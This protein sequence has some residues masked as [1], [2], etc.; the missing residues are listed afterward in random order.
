MAKDD[1]DVIV[2]NILVYLYKRLKSKTDVT[3]EIFLQQG[4]KDLPIS[5][6]YLYYVLE[7]MLK[8]NLIEGCVLNRAWGGDIINVNISDIKITPNGIHY[9]RDNSVM[10]VIAKSIPGAA[11]IASLFIK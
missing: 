8:D 9:L 6:E 2:C 4:T 3:E 7:H 5:Q 10:N 1:Y 11:S